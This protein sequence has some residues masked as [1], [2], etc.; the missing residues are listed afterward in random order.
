MRHFSGN[1][2][3]RAAMV[4]DYRKK[5][6]KI[7]DPRTNKKF[8]ISYS[9]PIIAAGLGCLFLTIFL[10]IFMEMVS[11]NFLL[12]WAGLFC[13]VW[14]LHILVPWFA[15]H[16][17]L[18]EQKLIN[19]WL[20]VKRFVIVK[21]LEDKIYK[22]PYKF[23]NFKLDYKCYGDFSAYLLKIHIF[24]K[25]YYLKSGKK[26]TKQTEEWEAWFHFSQIPKKG[27]MEIEFL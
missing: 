8:K 7:L 14:E 23:E 13:I 17:H 11:N 12:V 15:N 21:E 4:I 5:T 22:L 1:S 18:L 20:V 9:P 19:D 26:L 2:L 25:D 3:D 10:S 27:K 6:V 16:T 24:P